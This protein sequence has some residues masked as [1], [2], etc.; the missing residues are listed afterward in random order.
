MGVSP[1][2]FLAFRCVDSESVG[3]KP[4]EFFILALIFAVR[5][6]IS[7]EYCFSSDWICFLTS[8]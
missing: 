2:I 5:L 1:W 6:F 3:R 4:Y 7:E 8:V